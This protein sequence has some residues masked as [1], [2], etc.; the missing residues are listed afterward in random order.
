MSKPIAMA[1]GRTISSSIVG[2]GNVMLSVV[3]TGE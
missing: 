3:S 1:N 2:G